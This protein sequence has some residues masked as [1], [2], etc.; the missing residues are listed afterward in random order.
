MIHRIHQLP[1]PF[2]QERQFSRDVMW[3]K[4]DEF[5]GAKGLFRCELVT[6]SGRSGS[7]NKSLHL[8]KRAISVVL[9]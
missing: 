3:D 6:E 4:W 8:P 5:F 1:C 9:A 2:G 7:A